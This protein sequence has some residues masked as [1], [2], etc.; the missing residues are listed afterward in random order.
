LKK[1][2]IIFEKKVEKS[3]IFGKNFKNKKIL[4]K[5]FKKI[6]LLYLSYHHFCKKFFKILQKIQKNKKILKIQKIKNHEK[7]KNSISRIENKIKIYKY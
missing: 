2:K 3:K 4:T 6:S 1:V 5:N 7:F